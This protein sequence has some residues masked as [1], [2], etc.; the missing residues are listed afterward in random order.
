VIGPIDGSD[1]VDDVTSLLPHY[2]QLVFPTRLIMLDLNLKALLIIHAV[3][4]DPLDLLHSL[5]YKLAWVD[6]LPLAGFDAART[7][8]DRPAATMLIEIL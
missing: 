6:A 8:Q 5:D 2:F 3:L 7:V 1:I 4:V